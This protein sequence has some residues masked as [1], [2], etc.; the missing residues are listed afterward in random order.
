MSR[1]RWGDP[2]ARDPHRRQ[3]RVNDLIRRQLAMILERE[4]RDRL[5][6]DHGDE[7]RISGDLRHAAH[8]RRHPC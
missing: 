7:V 3:A 5:P 2:I 4:F 1:R 8:F 6:P